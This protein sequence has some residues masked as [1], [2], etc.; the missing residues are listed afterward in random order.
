MS[1]KTYQPR[2][3]EAFLGLDVDKSSFSFTVTNHFQSKKSKKM[4]SNPEHLYN[5]I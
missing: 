2:N 1:H 3:Y 4:P 5:Y